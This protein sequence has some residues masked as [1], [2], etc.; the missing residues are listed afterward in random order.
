MPGAT[1]AS[2]SV[3]SPTVIYNIPGTYTISLTASNASGTGNTYTAALVVNALPTVS[4]LGPAVPMCSG[5]GAT[6]VASGAASYTWAS[7]SSSAVI[8]TNTYAINPQVSNTYSVVGT[9]LGGCSSAAAIN[10]TVLPS[11]TISAGASRTIICKGECS[12]LTANGANTY[13]WS[14]GDN[15]VQIVVSPTLLSSFVYSVTG[16]DSNGCVSNTATVLIKV[17]S[18]FSGNSGAR[19]GSANTGCFGGPGA[20][21]EWQNLASVSIAPNP[22]NGF[23]TVSGLPQGE[24]ISLQVF[25]SRGREVWQH[26]GNAGELSTIQLH[27][28]ANGV[29]LFKIQSVSALR[30]FRIIKE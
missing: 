5:G 3:S 22:G 11:P 12:T 26:K 14:T 15:S 23:Y 19:G 16:T 2:A 25:D 1:T 8:T 18:C 27:D 17:A 6:L 13:T 10:V 9:S 21:G 7:I 28:L 29:Y 4:I 30:L 24:S 20:V